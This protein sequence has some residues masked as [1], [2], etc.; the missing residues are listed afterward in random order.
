LASELSAE[1]GEWRETT[2]MDDSLRAQIENY[3][4]RLDGL[5]SRGRQ[6]RDAL[7][8]DP[9]SA[10][11]I[12]ENRAWQEDCGVTI[13]QLSGGSK[14]HWLA[15]AFSQGFLMRS[16]DGRA[17][18]EVAP[19]EIVTR[20]LDVLEQAVASLSG[21]DDGAVISASSPS[22]QP[23]PRR[24]EFVHNAELQPVVEQAYIDSR[25]ALEQGDF[26]LALRT[27][28]G[29]L[30]AI[31]TDA[32][33]H[34]GLSA[35][36]A[37]GSPTGKIA[38]WSFETRLTVAERVGLIRGGCARLPA[39]ARAYRDH[40]GAPKVEVSERDARTTGQVLKVVMRDLDPGR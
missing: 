1:E 31:V 4:S 24:F 23:A 16:T 7:A 27:S 37:S 32:L 14:A 35:L 34:K 3:L 18:E 13:N 28:C 25:R 8:A 15:R 20:L 9:S 33:E 21:A 39:V 26:D 2:A 22:E 10:S 5:S 11:V 30:E 40:D 29:I 17:V 12:A 19:T 6:L 38:D 36:I